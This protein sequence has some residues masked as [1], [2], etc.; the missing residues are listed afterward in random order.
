MT[1]PAPPPHPVLAVAAIVFDAAGRVLLVER[2]RPPGVGLWSVPGGR[3]EHGESLA[4]A[5]AREVLEE[6]GLAIEVGP[7]VEVIERLLT[8]ADGAYHYVILD[9]LAAPITTDATDAPAAAPRGA[10]DARAARW[11]D[12]AELATLPLTDGLIPV[13]D[14]ARALHDSIANASR[15]R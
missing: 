7:L 2:G 10:D 14:A 11:V 5:V 6:T 9:F 8:G 1:S 15:A 3:V 4:A 12:A 13:I